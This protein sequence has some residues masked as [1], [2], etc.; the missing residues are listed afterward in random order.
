MQL[1]A[2]RCR[3]VELEQAASEAGLALEPAGEDMVHEIFQ[4]ALSRDPP[5]SH[6]GGGSSVPSPTTFSFSA[7]AMSPGA[8]G[9]MSDSPNTMTSTYSSQLGSTDWVRLP[10]AS[11]AGSMTAVEVSKGADQLLREIEVV[12][13]SKTPPAASTPPLP[14]T[15]LGMSRKSGFAETPTSRG[16]PM[17]SPMGEVGSRERANTIGRRVGSMQVHACLPPPV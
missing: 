3:R 14:P 16:S 5:N 10:V 12:K 9:T 8:G 7:S 11:G 6:P 4:Q 1:D 17:G 15:E 2:E 13:A